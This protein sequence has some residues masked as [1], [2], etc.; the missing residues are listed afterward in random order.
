M[1]QVLEFLVRFLPQLV[2]S[3]DLFANVESVLRQHELME[4]RGGVT[5]WTRS[6]NPRELVL[7]S[8]YTGWQAPAKM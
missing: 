7:P 2:T 5:Q 8:I 1:N 3:D 4:L 6:E